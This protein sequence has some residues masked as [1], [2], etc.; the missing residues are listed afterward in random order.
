M[1]I[2][3]KVTII[4]IFLIILCCLPVSYD[5]TKFNIHSNTYSALLRTK[6]VNSNNSLKFNPNRQTLMFYLKTDLEEN[7]IF[8]A[9]AEKLI[10]YFKKE[11][12]TESKTVN[13][14]TNSCLVYLNPL[15][16]NPKFWRFVKLLSFWYYPE[17]IVKDSVTINVVLLLPIYNYHSVEFEEIFQFVVIRTNQKPYQILIKSYEFNSTSTERFSKSEFNRNSDFP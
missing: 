3:T 16:N 14:L 10:D 2:L 9:D 1:K 8:D 17:I 4:S 7:S 6:K 11:N 15:F 12:L 13:E 5:S